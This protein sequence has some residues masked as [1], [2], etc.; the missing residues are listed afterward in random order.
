ML[1]KSISQSIFFLL[2]V[3]LIDILVCWHIKVY[4][5]L[6]SWGITF[7]FTFLCSSF[8]WDFWLFCTQSYQIQIFCNRSI[9]P[10]DETLTGTTTPSQ[11]EPGS[12]EL[13]ISPLVQVADKCNHFICWLSK[14]VYLHHL[15]DESNTTCASTLSFCCII[16]SC[17]QHGYPWPSLATSLYPSSP[18]AGLQSYILCLHIAAVCKFELVVLLLLGHMWGSIGV[19]HLWARP[20]FSSSVLH[21]WFV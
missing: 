8:F 18:L 17:R 14:Y 13:C 3:W 5:L 4:F 20:C 19:H 11:S 10:I 9:W 7:L 15:Q 12:N 21:V 1:F 2:I 6:T 16:V